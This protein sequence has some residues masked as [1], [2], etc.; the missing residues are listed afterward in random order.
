[1]PTENK[2]SSGPENGNRRCV[3]CGAVSL[4]HRGPKL[5]GHVCRV[6]IPIS[7]LSI[8]HTAC[9]CFIFTSGV[10]DILNTDCESMKR[11]PLVRRNEV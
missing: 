8:S 2:R 5:S 6:Q 10:H 9:W 3:G 11:P 4:V 1:M 7:D